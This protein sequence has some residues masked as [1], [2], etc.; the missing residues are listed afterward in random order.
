MSVSLS[1]RTAAG[2]LVRGTYTRV[3]IQGTILL[4]YL[5]LDVQGHRFQNVSVCICMPGV[6]FLNCMN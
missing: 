5:H 6:M 3:H 2:Y 4:H 1:S